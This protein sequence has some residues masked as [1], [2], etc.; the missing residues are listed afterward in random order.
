MR[1]VWATSSASCVSDRDGPKRRLRRS[2]A[3]SP[4]RSVAGS[5]ATTP[6]KAMTSGAYSG[7]INVSARNGSG[8]STRL[9][10]S[11]STQF[12]RAST[13]SNEPEPSKQRGARGGWPLGACE[14]A[15]CA[16]SGLIGREREGC[17]DRLDDLGIR[18]GVGH[19]V[20]P[21][22]CR[23]RPLRSS[24]GSSGSAAAAARGLRTDRLAVIG[25]G[26]PQAIHDSGGER[27]FGV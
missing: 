24:G 7:D 16:S 22:A 11:C 3:S 19:G 21:R 10:S 23:R 25:R 9:R 17:L 8:S 15:D 18:D 4:A 27:W 26:S 14:L 6:R 13:S 2:W 5:E 20:G 1:A 12:G